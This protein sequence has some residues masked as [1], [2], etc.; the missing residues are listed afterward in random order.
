MVPETSKQAP[1]STATTQL[2]YVKVPPAINLPVVPTTTFT[3][4]RDTRIQL[5]RKE[6]LAVVPDAAAEIGRFADYADVFGKTAPSQMAV[7]QTLDAAYQ[8][9]TL[10]TALVAWAEYAKI[11]EVA[12]WVS[13]RSLTARLR[14]AFALAVQTDPLIGEQNPSLA[15][16]LQTRSAIAK[17][18]V[19]TRVENKTRQA[20]GE[21]PYAGEVGKRRKMQDEKAALLAVREAATPSPAASVS[22]DAGQRGAIGI[23]T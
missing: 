20:R 5:P 8:W 9:T 19:A 3:P 21:P 17:R 13:T 11:Q 16:L 4:A 10:R 7:N 22:S 12:A 2:A 14:P 15:S 6:E 23:A 18:G 1:S